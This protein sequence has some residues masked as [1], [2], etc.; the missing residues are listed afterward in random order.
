MGSEPG[1]QS[2]C[3]PRPSLPFQAHTLDCKINL[4]SALKFEAGFPKGFIYPESRSHPLTATH[5]ARCLSL[6]PAQT[7]PLVDCKGSARILTHSCLV[8]MSK[9]LSSLLR[10]PEERKHFCGHRWF[11]LFPSL[12]DTLPCSRAHGSFHRDE[13]SPGP[14]RGESGRLSLHWQ[15]RKIPLN[16]GNSAFLCV[17]LYPLEEKEAKSWVFCANRDGRCQP[18]ATKAGKM[19]SWDLVQVTL[20]FSLWLFMLWINHVCL[21]LHKWLYL[22]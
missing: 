12:Y 9:H 6:P 4:K 8:F 22:Q 14:P 18:Q 2:Q 11:Y 5:T 3:S 13:V 16:T 17:N 10:T 21:W 19:S 15:L 20:L 1:C 7:G